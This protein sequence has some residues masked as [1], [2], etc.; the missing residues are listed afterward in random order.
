MSVSSVPF[1]TYGPQGLQVPATQDILNGVLADMSAA[2]GGGMNTALTTPQ[3]QLATTIAAAIAAS[4]DLLASIVNDVDPA[5]S[6]GRMQDAIGRLY[7]MTRTPQTYTSVVANCVGAQGTVIPAGARAQDANGIL[8]ACDTGGQ[9]PS[10]GTISL[11]FSCL[12]PGPIACPAGTLNVIYQAL[13]GWDSISNPADGTPGA[14]AETSAAFEARREASVAGNAFGP[15][16]PVLAALLN[17]AKT[18]GVVDAYVVDNPL[19][20]AQTIRGVSVAAHSLYCCVLGGADQ[21]VG[22]TIFTKLSPGAAMTGGTTVTVTDTNPAFVAPFPTYSIQFD[23]PAAVP[24]FFAVSIVN[25]TSVPSDATTQVQQ[26]ITAAFAKAA[27]MGGDIEALAY[28]GAV[29]ALGPWA[30]L[31]SLTVGTAV[32]P[33]GANVSLNINQNPTISAA[34]V[35]VTLV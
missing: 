6:S 10:G 3:G 16:A 26:A 1:P 23:R 29:A 9:I 15:A 18:P 34:N 5:Y 25:G 13:S 12:T 31:R 27:R 21:A 7:F 32:N 30:R 11:A 2:F 28:A 4:F 35:A 22:N 33:T 14:Y 24:I 17:P 19:A 20:T 8:Y